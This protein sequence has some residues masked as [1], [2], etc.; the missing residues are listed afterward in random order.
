MTR[1]NRTARRSRGRPP[2]SPN[3]PKPVEPTPQTLAKL[4]PDAIAS[5]AQEELHKAAA[6]IDRAYWALWGRLMCRASNLALASQSP[7][8]PAEF[9]GPTLVLILRYQAWIREAS[10]RRLH[11]AALVDMIV[12]GWTVQQADR[13][14]RLKPGTA[15][16]TLSAGLQLYTRTKVANLE[17]RLAETGD[18]HA[19]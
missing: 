15:A 6:A 11:T 1:A 18:Q 7:G 19:A 4:R 13:Y 5:L 12:D 14:H 9:S 2:G 3:K 17:A 8:K 10:R 16:R